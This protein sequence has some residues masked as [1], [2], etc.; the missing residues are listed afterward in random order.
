MTTPVPP[1]FAEAG[2]RSA[3][4]LTTVATVARAASTDRDLDMLEPFGGI[5]LR[6][7]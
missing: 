5:G 2:A 7:T 3:P 1:V 4:P 6:V